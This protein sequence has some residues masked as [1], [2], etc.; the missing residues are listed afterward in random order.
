[1]KHIT[2]KHIVCVALSQLPMV[3]N[4]EDQVI[5][6]RL[7]VNGELTAGNLTSSKLTFRSNGSLLINRGSVIGPKFEWYAIQ[8]AFRVGYFAPEPYIYPR[9]IS[10]GGGK[11][12]HTDAYSFGQGTASGSYS[13]VIGGSQAIA[14]GEGS[15]AGGYAAKAIG[16]RSLSLGFGNESIGYSSTAMGSDSRAIGAHSLS[17]G[18][19]T[20][21]GSSNSSVFGR[22]NVGG[23]NPNEWVETDPL[24]EIGNGKPSSYSE[25]DE[26]GDREY[27]PEVYSNAMTVYKNGNVEI[28]GVITCAP[29]GNIP[30]YD[31][32]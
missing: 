26:N 9:S 10:I 32:N 1:M 5:D 24:F 29:G 30:M 8:S 14:S 28:S 17:S 3:I 13:W 23:G 31:G 27:F 19:A 6:G 21:A 2:I 22:Y 16:N 15:F 11:I 18:E 12:E 25:P 7:T 20:N 4:A